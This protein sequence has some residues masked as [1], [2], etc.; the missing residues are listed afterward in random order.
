MSRKSS[1]YA[2]PVI[3]GGL[4][5]CKLL[6]VYLETGEHPY[7]WARLLTGPAYG[8]RSGIRLAAVEG[9]HH[10]EPQPVRRLPH[11]V[12]EVSGGKILELG[13]VV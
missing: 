4:Y 8:E 3:A 12:L 1:I 13:G 11:H 10:V 6:D 9:N 2:N 5:Y 7:V